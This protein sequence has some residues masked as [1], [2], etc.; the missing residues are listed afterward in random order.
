MKLREIVFSGTA[1]LVGALLRF[2]TQLGAMG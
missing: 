2:L 1:G